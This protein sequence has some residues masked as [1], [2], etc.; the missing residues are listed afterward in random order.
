MKTR[1]LL[2]ANL[3]LIATPLFAG[4]KTDVLIM[5]N[6]DRITC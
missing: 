6:G 1:L 2:I 5:K 3:L 4:E